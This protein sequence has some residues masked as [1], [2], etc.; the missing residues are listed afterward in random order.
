MADLR[1]D[2]VV[3]ETGGKFNFSGEKPPEGPSA[4]S[5]QDI[6][7]V[8]PKHTPKAKGSDTYQGIPGDGIVPR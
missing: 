6:T 2:H 5:P 7:K 3:S 8:A 1:P 4:K